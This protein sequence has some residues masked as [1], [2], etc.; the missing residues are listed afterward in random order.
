MHCCLHTL[1]ILYTCTCI[2]I[3][4]YCGDRTWNDMGMWNVRSPHPNERTSYGKNYF[5]LWAI[6]NYCNAYLFIFKYTRLPVSIVH[7]YLHGSII[8]M[9]Q[10]QND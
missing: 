9:L 1:C 8:L 3:P 5:T 7:E 10:H 4:T 6:T 2:L